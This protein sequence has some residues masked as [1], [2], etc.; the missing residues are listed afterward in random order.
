[1]EEKNRASEWAGLF[2]SCTLRSAVGFQGQLRET[3]WGTEAE[4]GHV[5]DC[6]YV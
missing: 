1:M 3:L 5:D 6:I 2:I 4:Y